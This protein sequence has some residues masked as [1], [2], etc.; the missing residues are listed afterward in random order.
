MSLTLSEETKN[1]W[2]DKFDTSYLSKIWA[3]IMICTPEI[4]KY[5]IHD[6]NQIKLINSNAYLGLTEKAINLVALNP[7]D[8]TKIIGLFSIP[9]DQITKID[10]QKK[11]FSYIVIFHLGTEIIRTKMNLV[12]IGTNIKDRRRNVENFI[13]YLK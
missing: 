4:Q 11:S 8:V 6:K 5:A 13:K 1:Q 3:T 7:L 12:A 9:R 10:I 2:L